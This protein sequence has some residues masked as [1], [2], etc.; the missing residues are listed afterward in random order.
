MGTRRATGVAA[1][2]VGA[3]VLAGCTAFGSAHQRQPLPHHADSSARA[4]PAPTGP[5]RTTQP[6]AV[7]PTPAV[8]PSGTVAAETEVVS[9]SGDTAIHVRVVADGHD[10]FVA[11]LTGYRSRVSQPMS[12]DFRTTL[13]HTQDGP[14]GDEYGQARWS[15]G[16]PPPASVD[17]SSVGD[18][19]T[20][21]KSVVLVPVGTPAEVA[22]GTSP[23]WADHVLAVAPLT[24]HVPNPR[25]DLHITVGPAHPYAYGTVI[26][27]ATGT[28]RQYLV[29]HGDRA[30]V[31][32]ARLGITV[33]DLHWLNPDAGF[34]ER[35]QLGER[36]LLNLDPMARNTLVAASS[37]GE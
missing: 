35:D 7:Q 3:C 25:P 2:L 17:L 19:P 12:L 24:W 5:A 4:V 13:P 22:A 8:L 31:V 21:L 29:A 27:D 37:G 6:V 15:A 34:H 18:N 23:P 26:D 30:I 11:Q 1:A 33:A 14:A 20:L 28:P 36:D 32:A 10:A 16:S 9:P